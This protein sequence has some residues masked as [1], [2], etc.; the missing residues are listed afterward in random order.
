MAI[1]THM[2]STE[3]IVIKRVFYEDNLTPDLKYFERKHSMEIQ[4]NSDDLKFESVSDFKFA[5][6]NGGEIEFEWNGI[7]YGAFREGENE[8][9][10][11]LCEAY[12]ND[13]GVFFKTVDE[14]L[15]YVIDGRPLRE[16]V[17]EVT[18]NWR[19]V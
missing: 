19:N 16:F 5:L 6:I 18:V 7:S 11:F 10:F 14:L 2:V 9:I 15:D 8:D 3:I 12:K 1:S 17:T 13:D 4:V